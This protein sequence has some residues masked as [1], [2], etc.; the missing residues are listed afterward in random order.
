MPTHNNDLRIK[1]KVS[2]LIT[3]LLIDIIWKIWYEN[4]SMRNCTILSS[5]VCS[6]SINLKEHDL[7][8]Q[9]QERPFIKN[10]AIFIIFFNITNKD[11][12]ISNK[13]NNADFSCFNYIGTGKIMTIILFEFKSKIN[14]P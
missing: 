10:F 12:Q 13:D 7:T 8:Q 9:I 11:K 2:Y 14:V 6:Y 4:D 3:L 5:K 1:I